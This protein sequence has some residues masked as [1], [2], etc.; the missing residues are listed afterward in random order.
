[1]K[2][3]EK[4][5]HI[6]WALDPPSKEEDESCRVGYSYNDDGEIII[7]DIKYIKKEN[8][9][10][11]K[12]IDYKKLPY[13]DM[14]VAK[15]K[16]KKYLS[17]YCDDCGK[18]IKYNFPYH[19]CVKRNGNWVNGEN[20]EKIKF[21]CLCN[22]GKNCYGLITKTRIDV[23]HTLFTLHEINKQRSSYSSVKS[24]P[25]LKALIENWNIHI[26][27]GKLIIYESEE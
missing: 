10:V 13:L 11:N 7:E 8:K 17:I 2:G 14:K 26:L 20:L 25:D 12:E 3:G 19:F 16:K 9:K 4:M 22:Y 1:M 21:P 5:S 15:V 27:K 23:D 18:H 24:Y 6:Y